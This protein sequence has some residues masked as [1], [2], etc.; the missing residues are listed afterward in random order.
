MHV[1]K[2]S[3]YG[4]TE[5]AGV[6]HK[7][8]VKA[9]EA[10]GII[11]VERR[12]LFRWAKA[13]RLSYVRRNERG[14][15]MFEY[16][17]IRK[18]VNC[19]TVEHIEPSRVQKHEDTRIEAI[20]AR[21]S[22]RKQIEHLETQ[23]QDLQAKFPSAIVFRDCASGLNFRRKGLLSLLQQVLAGNVR[24]VHVA[25]RDRL[26]RFAYDLIER[27]FKHC[28]TTITVEAHDSSSPESELADD[29]LSI[30]TVF[31]ARLYG[32][33]SRGARLQKAQAGRQCQISTLSTQG[34]YERQAQELQD[35][36]ASH[37]GTDN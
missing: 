11:G 35:S 33:R 4:I 5:D 9:T 25:Y 19:E 12:T 32:K 3:C 22:T 8:F 31:S 28:G 21:V 30:I 2:N 17:S 26:C 23:I 34:A 1:K 13:G 6:H 24:V 15:W 18:L 27:V 10:E 14:H 37:K 7:L 20:Y 16:D 36:N 29:V